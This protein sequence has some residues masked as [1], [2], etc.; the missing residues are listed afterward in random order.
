[1]V[2][3]IARPGRTYLESWARPT[4]QVES[5]GDMAEVVRRLLCV[6]TTHDE[7]G[8]LKTHLV[9]LAD[10]VCPSALGQFDGLP[11]SGELPARW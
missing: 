9:G 6:V 5:D 7:V 4:P 3:F 8:R 2:A 1:M 10:P 11:C